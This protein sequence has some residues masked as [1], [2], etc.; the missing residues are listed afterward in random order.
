MI[1]RQNEKKVFLENV[2]KALS[3]QKAREQKIQEPLTCKCVKRQKINIEMMRIRPKGALRIGVTY[4]YKLAKQV[5][6]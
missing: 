4:S 2:Y 6:I 1:V 3:N 5:K